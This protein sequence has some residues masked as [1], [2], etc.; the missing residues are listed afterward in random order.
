MWKNI[1]FA[2]WL[3]TFTVPKPEG[4]QHFP[5]H[6]GGVYLNTDLHLIKRIPFLSQEE[7]QSTDGSQEMSLTT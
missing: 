2:L 3:N 4:C 5:L 7:G 6:L 1:G